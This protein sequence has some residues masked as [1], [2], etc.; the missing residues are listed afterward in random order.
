MSI[1]VEIT[2]TF[3]SHDI[4][5]LGRVK[6]HSLVIVSGVMLKID[7]LSE[8]YFIEF[9]STDDE[10]RIIELC[11]DVLKEMVFDSMVSKYE[12]YVKLMCQ[13]DVTDDKPYIYRLEN[14]RIGRRS[15]NNQQPCFV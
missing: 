14:D 3:P 5:A 12:E 9:P 4:L 13:K 15:R 2:D 7:D 10:E 1:I 8:K 11:D 6:L